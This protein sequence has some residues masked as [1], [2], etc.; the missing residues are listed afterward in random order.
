[1]KNSP[2]Y[3]RVYLAGAVLA[4]AALA[5]LSFKLYAGLADTP[6]QARSLSPCTQS[7]GGWHTMAVGLGMDGL[8]AATF[9]L[10]LPANASV[11]QAWLLWS[12]N[13][14]GS[15]AG[16][17]PATFNPALQNGDPTVRL[18]GI[19]VPHPQ[20][21][22]GPA[23]WADNRYAY[24]YISDVS[25]IVVGSGDYVL[26]GMDNFDGNIGYNNGAEL[27]VL[28]AL[29]GSATTMIGIAEGLDLAR[30][31]IQPTSGPGTDPVF[32]S[33]PPTTSKQLARLTVVVGGAGFGGTIRLWTLTG[34]G[35]APDP[36]TTTLWQMPGALSIENP[37]N[38][39]HNANSNGYWD[40]WETTVLVPAGAQW[41]GVQV[42]SDNND[43]TEVEWVAAYFEID[44][45]C[46]YTVFTPL[47][48]Q[49]H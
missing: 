7:G 5:L 27:L 49:K 28:Y 34:N 29:P 46:S 23:Y 8:T 22:G 20:R 10:E 13:D 12:G 32:F 16:D 44:A 17:D 47:L 25:S 18:N 38:G 9:P 11:Q 26:S 35:S 40:S 19:Q 1:M 36:A 39:L 45:A 31:E 41:L 4:L 43:L 33:F 14:P 48:L 15:N 30:G 42:E 37:F 24:A 2:R 6:L 21:V 3:S